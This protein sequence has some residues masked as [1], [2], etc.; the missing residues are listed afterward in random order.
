MTC[1]V[2]SVKSIFHEPWWL[3]A[4]TSG[5]YEEVVVEQKGRVVG[6][7][8]YLPAQ[9]GPFRLSRMPPFTHLLGP[10]IDSGDGK[11]QTRLTRRLSI[12]RALIDK[13]PRF[14]HFEQQFDPSLDDG[15]A[16][17]DGL[18]FQD[19]GFAI[20]QRYTYQID[21]RRDLDHLWNA[22]H[23]KTR[24]HIRRAEEKYVARTVDDPGVFTDAYLRNT[25]A[26][27]RTN[28]MDFG[29]FPALFA[30][31]R[32]RNCGEI[33]AAFAPDGSPVSMV[34]LV[35]SDTAM[36]YL[37]STRHPDPAD[38]G[39]TSML[40]W[41][42]VKNAHQR[43]LT[44]DLDGIYSSGAA[45]FLIGFGGQIRTRLMVRRSGPMFGAWLYLKQCCST[46]ET[47]HFM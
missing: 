46:N 32:A 29:R 5:R 37:L 7:L 31:C 19:R 27:G 42:A 36:Y 6:R 4:A 13:L 38:N 47:K 28:L 22:M 15:L 30:Q 33:L 41:S 34:F 1:A 12:A 18:A 8:P 2:E 43:G 3:S 17:A 35:W 25:Q 45:R 39:S 20:L 10:V 40:L 44:F 11:P 23:F 16:R 9:R 24:Q 14:I 26:L 21:G